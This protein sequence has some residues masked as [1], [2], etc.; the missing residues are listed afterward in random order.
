MKDNQRSVYTSKLRKKSNVQSLHR[1]RK[2]N[3]FQ[4]KTYIKKMKKL[5][6]M[7]KIEKEKKITKRKEA[8]LVFRATGKKVQCFHHRT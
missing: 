8:F 4:R 3:E 7:K 1:K 6:M 2:E 5:E